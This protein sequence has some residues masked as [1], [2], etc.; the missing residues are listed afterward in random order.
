M[1][2]GYDFRRSQ[3]NRAVQA[4]R[5]PGSAFKPI[6]YAAALDKGMTPASIIVDAP[7]EY[8]AT[9]QKSWKPRNYDNKFRGPVTMREALTNSI[10]VVSVKILEHIGVGYAIEYA[11]KLGVTSPLSPISRLRSAH[12][13][14]TPLELTSAYA[15]FASGGYRP[16][17]F[18]IT[19]VMDSDG[20]ILEEIAPPRFPVFHRCPQRPRKS[21]CAPEYTETAAFAPRFRPFHR[22]PVLSSAT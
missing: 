15:V 7:I 3:F 20:K 13:A 19:K 14:V 4:H 6:I 2:G 17:P 22:K 10:N 21:P 18:F 5:N 1:I 9:S 16:T 8:D 12:Q 11:K